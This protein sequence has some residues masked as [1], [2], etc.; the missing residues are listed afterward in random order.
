VHTKALVARSVQPDVVTA[1]VELE[2]VAALGARVDHAVPF[3]G[4]VIT[5]AVELRDRFRAMLVASHRSTARRIR[6]H[7]HRAGQGAHVARRRRELD[8]RGVPLG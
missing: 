8:R 1:F 7:V 3:D 2:G 4:D 6:A 5:A